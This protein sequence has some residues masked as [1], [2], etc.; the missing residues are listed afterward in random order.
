MNPLYRLLV[1]ALVTAIIALGGRRSP[2]T[3][4]T[5]GTIDQIAMSSTI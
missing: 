3:M 5:I 4:A 1:C 2:P